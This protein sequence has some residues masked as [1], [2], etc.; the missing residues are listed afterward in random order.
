MTQYQIDTLSILGSN[1]EENFNKNNGPI[2][3]F[4]ESS[5]MIRRRAHRMNCVVDSRGGGGSAWRIACELMNLN[6]VYKKQKNENFSSITFT[7]VFKICLYGPCFDSS[8]YPHGI[9]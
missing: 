8:V 6:Q 1:T 4:Q 7:T 3:P 2:L 9:F 5:R